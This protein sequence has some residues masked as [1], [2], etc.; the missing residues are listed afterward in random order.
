MKRTYTKSGIA[1]MKSATKTSR[2]TSN[3]ITKVKLGRQL[4]KTYPIFG[5]Y[6]KHRMWYRQSQVIK[7]KNVEIGYYRTDGKF[8]YL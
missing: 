2:P 3:L 4:Y 6:P 5:Y 1:K 8:E 7:K